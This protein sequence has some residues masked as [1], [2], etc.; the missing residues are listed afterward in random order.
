MSALRQSGFS[1]Y[2]DP[3]F[4]RNA[5]NDGRHREAVGGMWD[6]MGSLQAEFLRTQGLLPHHALVDVGAGAFR[7]GVKL[8]SY[9]DPGNYYAIDLAAEFLEAGYK[10]EIE[11]AGLAERFPRRN[12]AATGAFDLSSFQRRFDFGIAQSVFTHMPIERLSL[13][14]PA[15]QPY[16][17]AG[18][19]FFATV[20]LVP[21]GKARKRF[22]QLPGGVVTAPDRDPFH[23]TLTALH[24]VASQA[25]GWRMSVIGNWNHPRNQQMVLFTRL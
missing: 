20:F 11:P 14:L 9:L 12:F 24:A 2:D 18:G 1:S 6:E 19:K 25:D 10:R 22:K 8:I 5:V 13:C 4:V 16:F 17:N 15:I 3:N 23:T 21:E 7:A